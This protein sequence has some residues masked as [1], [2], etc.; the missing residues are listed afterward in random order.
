MGIYS[1]KNHDIHIWTVQWIDFD[2]DGKLFPKVEVHLSKES[3]MQK[4][5]ELLDI[6]DEF[7][8]KIKDNP[9][10]FGNGL[11]VSAYLI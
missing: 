5:S 11:S 10:C 6:Q 4:A 9:V 7:T 1:K 2:E 8:E 3:A